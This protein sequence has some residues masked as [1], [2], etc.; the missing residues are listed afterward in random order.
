M[1]EP[2][3]PRFFDP[4]GPLGVHR[5]HL[6][7]WSQSGVW[8]FVTW[9]LADSLPAALLT[10]WRLQRDDWLARHPRPWTPEQ[11][12]DYVRCFG[13][14]V[15]R[16]LDAGHGAC[17][18][19]DPVARALVATSL[20]AGEPLR[21]HLDAYAIMPNHV[22]VL[23]APRP[24]EDWTLVLKA[25]KGV[26]ARRINQLR[27]GAGCPWHEEY[28]DRL[29]RDAEHL[30][31]VRRYIA[32]NPIK[33]HLASTDYTVWSSGEEGGHSCPSAATPS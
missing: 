29:I 21:F 16:W 1:S 13:V 8:V 9:H 3:E 25:W 17:V 15:E 30:A 2:R 22:H 31:R 4:Q 6:P 12:S 14:P 23:F 5:R 7:H 11:A 24:G 27:G 19:R 10:P 26:S 28:W 33:S 20:H 32:Q 18:L